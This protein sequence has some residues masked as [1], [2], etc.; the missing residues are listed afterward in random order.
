MTAGATEPKPNP[1]IVIDA[2]GTVVTI[3][4]EISTAAAKVPPPAVGLP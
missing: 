4:E 3:A 2:V 1:L